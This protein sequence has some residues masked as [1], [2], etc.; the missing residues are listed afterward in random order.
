[1]PPWLRKNVGQQYLVTSRIIGY[2]DE[3]RLGGDFVTT[4][5]DKF[6]P[7]DVRLFLQQ[8]H[9]HV[10]E[11]EGAS[12]ERALSEALQQAETYTARLLQEI[13]THDR[14]REFV[15]N[16]LILTVIALLHRE[17]LKLP[18]RRVDL[19][20]KVVELMLGRRDERRGVESRAVFDHLLFGLEERQEVFQTIALHMHARAAK[21]IDVG[22]LK[23][24][25]TA[26]FGR[27]TT[28]WSVIERAVKRFL[29]NVLE[30]TGLLVDAGNE[31]YSFPHLSFQEYLVA[32]QMADSETY[33]EDTLKRLADPFWREA[34]RLEFGCL[35]KDRRNRLLQAMYNTSVA[36]EQGNPLQNL[37]LAADCLYDA[38]LEKID[39]AVL[40]E[41]RQRL[42]RV[43]AE[44]LP[45]ED[46]A[47][48]EEAEVREE[49]RAFAVRRVTAVWALDKIADE[50]KLPDEALTLKSPYWSPPFGES[51]WVTI[52]AGEFS[53]GSEEYDDESPVHRVFVS[54]FRIARTPVTNVQYWFYV[55]DK[56]VS[57]PRY[58]NGERP[59]REELNHPVVGVSWEDA[60]GYCAWLSEKV[61]KLVR[62]PTEA[63]WEKVARGDL[64]A[65]RYSWGEAFDVA[66]CNSGELWESGQGG[67]TPVGLFPEGCSFYKCLDMSGN[68]WE[69]VQDWYGEHYYRKSPKRD[70]RGPQ[71]GEARV[72]RG[73]SWVD[74]ARNLRVSRRVGYDPGYR[75][76]GIGF[77]CAV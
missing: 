19:Y 23:D 70:P 40:T 66:K 11:L 43:V 61:G 74:A 42:H 64:G 52:P 34:I 4:T 26:D 9:R 17:D 15:I 71:K 13:E 62:L 14:L 63:E 16:P 72:L 32:R 6:T 60:Q 24:L 37:M 76:V 35:S 18:E 50:V 57:P 22:D 1:M 27:R 41:L 31:S 33:V 21:E 46:E 36:S 2:E 3:T 7:D 45:V 20:A 56:K 30:R 67:T 77:R 75:N 39:V 73:G 68:V 65:C 49:R 59:P 8:W 54:E 38:G 48:V 25:L 69:W 55:H 53:M 29:Q 44:P 51:E 12:S 47:K 58:W 28:E 10:A 5:I